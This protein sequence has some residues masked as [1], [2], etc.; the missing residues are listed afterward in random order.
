[1]R[2]LEQDFQ[3]IS[4]F[5]SSS[6]YRM[7]VSKNLI[8]RLYRDIEGGDG[9]ITISQYSSQKDQ[10]VEK[11]LTHVPLT[12]VIG[13]DLSH[14]SAGKHTSGEAVYTDDQLEHLNCLY[15]YVG[16]SQIARGKIKKVDLT[17][18]RQAE[19]V[20][21]VLTLEDIPGHWDI[22]PVFPGDPVLAGP[23]LNTGGSQYS[24]WRQ[25]VNGWQEKL[26]AWRRS[27]MKSL[28]RVS[29]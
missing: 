25:A 1:M 23:R 19:G 2:E 10:A 8:R 29:V 26:L 5:R 16:L 17:A 18:V 4:D 20:S 22:G 6:A 24:R 13:L 28:N 12:G 7:E 14:D 21:E 11:K 15:A 9:K 27:N 3:P